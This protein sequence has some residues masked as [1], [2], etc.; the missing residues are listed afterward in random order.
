VG[1]VTFGQPFGHGRTRQ[2]TITPGGWPGF[3]A[4]TTGASYTASLQNYDWWRLI[5]V[6][7]V[8]TTDG[9]AAN[10]VYTI[11]YLDGTGTPIMEDGPSV[12]VTA[13]TTAQ[14]FVG[15]LARSV[16]SWNTPTPIWFPLSGLWLEIGRQVKINVA[17]VQAGDTLASVRFTFDV[18]L[19]PGDGT[20]E[21]DAKAD[22]AGHA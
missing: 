6:R 16:D 10:R 2:V 20:R 13:S 11:Q 3:G 18:S 21:A 22:A 14:P 1:G 15:Q 19:T 8:A 12:L 5:G 9:N 7:F 4:L 17:S